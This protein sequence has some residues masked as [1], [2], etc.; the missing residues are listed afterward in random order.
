MHL[1]MLHHSMPGAP[2]HSPCTGGWAACKARVVPRRT[3][4]L[5][6]CTGNRGSQEC[7]SS[8]VWLCSCVLPADCANLICQF[9]ELVVRELEQ[10]KASGG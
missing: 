1:Y 4:D 5:T 2:H 3:A 9:A 8:S 7:A 10:D 6:T